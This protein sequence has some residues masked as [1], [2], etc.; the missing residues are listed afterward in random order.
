MEKGRDNKIN[1]KEGGRLG[2]LQKKIIL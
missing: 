2:V 1:K